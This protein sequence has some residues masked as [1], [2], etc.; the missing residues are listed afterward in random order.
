MEIIEFLFVKILKVKIYTKFKRMF[1]SEEG[2]NRDW[3]LGI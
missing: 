1:I 2:E 3:D